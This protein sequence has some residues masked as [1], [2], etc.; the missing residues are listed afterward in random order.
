MRLV[1]EILQTAQ[2]TTPLD[3]SL[4]EIKLSIIEPTRD[5][6]EGL[7]LVAEGFFD[8]VRPTTSPQ[9]T[10]YREAF[11]EIQKSLVSEGVG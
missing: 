2:K 9:A 4:S 8:T 11:E 6:L 10:K 7:F 3:Q 1:E 5:I